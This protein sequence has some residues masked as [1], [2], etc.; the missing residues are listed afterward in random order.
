MPLGANAFTAVRQGS[1]V[2][3]DWT[4]ATGGCPRAGWLLAYG[5]VGRPATTSLRLDPTANSWTIAGLPGN[6]SYT[7]SLRSFAGPSES[8]AN[9]A[10][11]GVP[12]LVRYAVT[13]TETGLKP[14][15]SW[16]VSLSGTVR[17]APAGSAIRFDEPNGSYRISVAGVAGYSVG[18]A[19]GW[20]N[21]SGAALSVPI[22]FRG[23]SLPGGPPPTTTA[24]VFLGPAPAA[25]YWILGGIGAAL[26]ASVAVVAAIRRRKRRG[27]SPP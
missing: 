26:V 6:Q 22:A 3:L 1:E 2:R 24:P 18:R 27:S 9:L 7:F 23:V 13:F 12:V 25:D 5:A 8:G 17:S 10:T 15:V 11:L 20:A 14:D 21:V 16:S 4:P 19:S